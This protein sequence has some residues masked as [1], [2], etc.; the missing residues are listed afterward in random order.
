M[1]RNLPFT[2]YEHIY[3]CKA[4]QIWLLKQDPANHSVYTLNQE[5]DDV[6]G[7]WVAKHVDGYTDFTRFF[8]ERGISLIHAV[9]DILL[10][11]DIYPVKHGYVFVLEKKGLNL[12]H[13]DQTTN[14]IFVNENDLRLE[15]ITRMRSI[16]IHTPMYLKLRLPLSRE[17]LM[18]LA[19]I[20]QDNS[21]LMT[22]TY[23]S[24]PPLTFTY[25]GEE[26]TLEPAGYTPITEKEVIA[27]LRKILSKEELMN[28]INNAGFKPMFIKEEFYRD[29][30]GKI[31][32]EKIHDAFNKLKGIN[33]LDLGNSDNNGDDNDNFRNGDKLK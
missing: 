10:Y 17:D 13:I 15:A 31:Y 33:N 29:P 25:E 22:G 30:L 8:A 11:G 12:T 4:E 6:F 14:L 26:Y 28:Q 24:P 16:K 19:K 21:I 32:D 2:Q 3:D 20:S 9:I 1:L 18:A 5:S 23:K 27:D 7:M